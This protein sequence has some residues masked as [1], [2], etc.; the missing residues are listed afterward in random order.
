MVAV[1]RFDEREGLVEQLG[2][3]RPRHG[4]KTVEGPPQRWRFLRSPT[5]P[6]DRARAWHCG[7]IGLDWKN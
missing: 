5:I 7:R 2:F 4:A 1:C 3:V 6:D